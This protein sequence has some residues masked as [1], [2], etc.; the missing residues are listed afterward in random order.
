MERKSMQQFLENSPFARMKKEILF[1][2]KVAD[3]QLENAAILLR[4]GGDPCDASKIASRVKEDDID[5]WNESIVD[6][7]PLPKKNEARVNAAVAM[8][9]Q[10]R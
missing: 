1:E 6:V 10:S 8:L 2:Q 3:E 7:D 9:R 5:V 4:M